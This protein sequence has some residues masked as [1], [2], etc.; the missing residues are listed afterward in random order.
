[1]PVVEYVK[2]SEKGSERLSRLKCPHD[3]GGW[4]LVMKGPRERSRTHC[5]IVGWYSP[6]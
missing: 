2:T 1:V 3:D 5:V 6:P 4:I